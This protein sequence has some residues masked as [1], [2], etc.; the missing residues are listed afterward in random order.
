MW[1]SC[2]GGGGKIANGFW[3]GC[4]ARWGWRWEP[5][6]RS[7]GAPQQGGR[8]RP[9][10]K[11]KQRSCRR[12][13]REATGF[14][15]HRLPQRPSEGAFAR[16]DLERWGWPQP[17]HDPNGVSR[18][19]AVAGPQHC[20]V[21][22]PYRPGQYRFASPVAPRDVVG[23]RPA[24]PLQHFP[25]RFGFEASYRHKNPFLHCIRVPTK[26]LWARAGSM[27]AAESRSKR[28]KCA[29][30]HSLN[31]TFSHWVWEGEISANGLLWPIGNRLPH[32]RFH[33]VR[34]HFRT[35]RAEPGAPLKN[36]GNAGTK[37]F[38]RGASD[39]PDRRNFGASTAK[40][41]GKPGVEKAVEMASSGLL[42]ERVEGRRQR[43][44]LEQK[45]SEKPISCQ[46]F[47]GFLWGVWIDSGGSL[48]HA[49]TLAGVTLAS[50]MP[51]CTSAS[52]GRSTSVPR[53]RA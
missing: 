44:H 28:H 53:P 6:F 50:S 40:T 8:H 49:S 47:F 3:F 35:R 2:W 5:R 48:N 9:Q 26:A 34:M 13:L 11:R 1:S 19:P 51:K 33:A 41:P 23:T 12:L 43:S 38:C 29:A 25:K 45:S 15:L 30:R 46:R 10:Q 52:S 24:V 31:R 42:S 18:T 32:S 37:P 39:P 22:S 27:R 21:R 16:C 36:R 4:A 14:V 17:D 20:I 7:S